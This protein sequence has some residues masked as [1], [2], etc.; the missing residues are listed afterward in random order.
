[1]LQ[2]VDRFLKIS[3]AKPAEDLIV[4]HCTVVKSGS[5]TLHAFTRYGAAMLRNPSL[6]YLLKG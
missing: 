4:E 6:I 5:V 2:S 3:G 1:L